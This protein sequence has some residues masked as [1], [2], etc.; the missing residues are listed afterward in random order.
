MHPMHTCEIAYWIGWRVLR[1]SVYVRTVVA[2]CRR[3]GTDDVRTGAVRRR[4]AGKAR[5]LPASW[6]PSLSAAQLFISAVRGATASLCRNT[7]RVGL[8]RTS[9]RAAL[10]CPWSAV[11]LRIISSNTDRLSKN[12]S[13]WDRAVNCNKVPVEDSAAPQ[14]YRY[15]VDL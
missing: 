1:G 15:T 11:F 2:R 13:A 4:S 5:L 9:C 7:C 3:V 10:K 6:I 8:Q 14:R 12:F